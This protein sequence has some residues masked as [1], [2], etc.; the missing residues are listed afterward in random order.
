MVLLAHA[1]EL[2]RGI[3]YVLERASREHSVAV[4]LVVSLNIE[5]DAS[6]RLVGKSVVHDLLHQLFLLDDMS[7][8]MGLYA[9][10]QHAE[11]IH[12]LVVAVGVVLCYL[13]RLELF[14]ACLLGYLVLALVG[15]VL[16]MAHVGDVT[17]VAHL[18]AQV[19]E[20]AEEHVEGDCRARMAQMGVAI[21][22]G[23]THV[24]AHV[25]RIDGLETLLRAAKGV[26]YQ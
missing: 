4:F 19:A 9:W 18:V 2:A 25:G 20:V 23:T 13:H 8:G 3:L 15:I 17:H 12:C 7:R 22:G 21:D 24:H 6:V 26:V 1:V 14:E 5:V 10:A 11:G 16:Q